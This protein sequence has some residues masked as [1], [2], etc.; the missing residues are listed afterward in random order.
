[1][2]LAIYMQLRVRRTNKPALHASRKVNHLN[3][4]GKIK[5]VVT[6]F[7]LFGHVFIIKALLYQVLEHS[8]A[9]NYIPFLTT[10]SSLSS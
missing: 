10:A 4:D 2:V 8:Q 3:V 1:M 7:F 5:C 6:F 9:V